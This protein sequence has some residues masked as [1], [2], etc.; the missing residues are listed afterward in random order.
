MTHSVYILFKY[1]DYTFFQGR[2]FP[3]IEDK[4]N[5]HGKP[6]GAQSERVLTHLRSLMKNKGQ[7]KYT[8]PAPLSQVKPVDISN[9]KMSS[10]PNYKQGELL[11]TRASYGTALSKLAQSNPR[12]L[13]LDGDMSNSTFSEAMK[14]SGKNFIE[15]YIAEQNLVGVGTGAACRDRAVVFLSTFACFLTRAFDQVTDF[16]YSFI[17]SVNNYYYYCLDS[18][19]SHLTIQ[20]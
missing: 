10:P 7:L 11:A 2:D 6:L 20:H 4:D 1:F 8:I 9:I 14:K 16:Y 13:A 12:I 5:W 17:I 18:Y 15:C 19:G 3:D